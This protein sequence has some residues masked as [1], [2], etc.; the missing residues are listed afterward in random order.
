MSINLATLEINTEFA[1]P[2][3]LVTNIILKPG[4]NKKLIKINLIR[5]RGGP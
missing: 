2:K 5:V 3:C 1:V 4:K